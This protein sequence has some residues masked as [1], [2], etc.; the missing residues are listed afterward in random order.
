M[1]CDQVIFVNNA[2]GARVSSDTALFKMD[3]FG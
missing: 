2:A 3:R 1:S